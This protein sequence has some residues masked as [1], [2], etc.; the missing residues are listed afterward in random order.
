MN[1]KITNTWGFP[2][3]TKQLSVQCRTLPRAPQAGKPRKKYFLP[4]IKLSWKKER[5]Q[6][7]KK[8]LQTVSLFWRNPWIGRLSNPSKAF[9]NCRLSNRLTT[10]TGWRG[11]G[12]PRSVREDPERF[13]SSSWKA[14]FLLL[15]WKKSALR[16]AL[17]S[18]R[19]CRL[20]QATPSWWSYSMLAA[21]AL[22]EAL[23]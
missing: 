18:L 4:K 5:T 16:V 14:S 17:L 19:P 22:T 3:K 11:R 10:A 8:R 9:E 15:Q 23:S 1:V 6:C 12:N 13:G 7:E 20:F 2:R 21:S